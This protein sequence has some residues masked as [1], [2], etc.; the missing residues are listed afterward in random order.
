M[1]MITPMPKLTKQHKEAL[2]KGRR[3]AKAVR[4]YLEALNVDKRKITDPDDL[5]KRI[6]DTEQKIGDEADPVHGVELIQRRLDLEAELES[7]QDAPDFEELESGFKKAVKEYSERK[8]ISYPA[9]RELGVPAGVLRDAGV[10]R[11]RRAS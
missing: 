7:A 4:D 10:P 8:G 5:K 3:Q 6:A 2:A 11:T 9:W 1:R